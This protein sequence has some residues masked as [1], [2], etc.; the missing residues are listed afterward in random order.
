[1]KRLARV[2]LNFL[3][4]AANRQD[5]KLHKR[6]GVLFSTPFYTRGLIMILEA[7][8]FSPCSAT[9]RKFGTRVNISLNCGVLLRCTWGG[10][11][12]LSEN[13][14]NVFDFGS[15][16]VWWAIISK[17]LTCFSCTAQELNDVGN[18]YITFFFFFFQKMIYRKWLALLKIGK[19][20]LIEFIL[21]AS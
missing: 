12:Y 15:V 1:M 13:N 11:R 18:E 2:F 4:L 14:G 5:F 7:I 21:L 8:G 3:R 19:G 17:Y 10:R 16:F 20:T 6:A 9:L